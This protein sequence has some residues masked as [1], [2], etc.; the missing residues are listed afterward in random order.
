MQSKIRVGLV[1]VSPGRGF[2][3]IA[4]V[5]ALRSLPD[6]EIVALCTSRQDSAEAAAKHYGVPLAFSDPVK[7]ATHPDV[8]LVAVTV[9]VPDHYPPVMAAIDAGKH[10]YCEWPLGRS[11]EEAERMA[12]AAARRGVRHMVGLQGRGSPAINYLRDLLADGYIGKVLSAS[13]LINAANWGKTLDR[14]YQADPRN[15]ANLLTVTAAHNLDTL[16]YCLGEFC[17]LSA[18]A[19]SQRT[20]VPLQATGE[21]IPLNVPDQIAINGVTGDGAVVSFQARG[22]MWRGHTF[23]FEIHGEDGDLILTAPDRASSQR[24]ELKLQGAQGTKAPLT[25]MAIPDKYR[26]VP[27]S[28]PIDSPYNV[29]QMYARLGDA[30]RGGTPARPGFDHAVVR[31]RLLDAIRK[32][33][34]T[35][36]RQYFA[37]S[38]SQ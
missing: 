17:E 32:A 25:D 28:T 37:T 12:Q 20:H 5:P 8:D 14:A 16:S 24:Q 4:H 18:F 31:L 23:L 27:S 11:T 33:S 13:M 3:S 1:G 15:G 7:L 21:L 22:G 19:V 2:A 10:V 30:I 34:D 38:A 9:K 36:E 6:F 26:W 29:A 35:G